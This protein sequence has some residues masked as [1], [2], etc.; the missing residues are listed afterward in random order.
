VYSKV[1]KRSGDGEDVVWVNE[2]T[3]EELKGEE[4]TGYETNDP[5]VRGVV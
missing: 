3:G 2:N 5:L 1:S 4:V